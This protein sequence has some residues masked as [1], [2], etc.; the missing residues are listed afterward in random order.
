VSCTR[1]DVDQRLFRG[2]EPSPRALGPPRLRPGL[3]VLVPGLKPSGGSQLCWVH[4]DVPELR[5][6]GTDRYVF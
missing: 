3:F 4:A 5:K 1:V 2:I 6:P